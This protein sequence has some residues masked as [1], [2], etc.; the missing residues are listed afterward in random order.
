MT[1]RSGNV[2]AAY[3]R[4][5]A[6]GNA[7]NHEVYSVTGQM[8]RDIRIRKVCAFRALNVRNNNT[9]LAGASKKRSRPV[10]LR[11]AGGAGVCWISV[12][13]K[14]PND[15]GSRHSPATLGHGFLRQPTI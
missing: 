1:M 8:S 5:L 2:S 15:V 6:D 11:L 9:R 4:I 14:N 13:A 7:L 10:A 3:D 12:R